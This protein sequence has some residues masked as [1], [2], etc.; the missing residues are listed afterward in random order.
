M[1]KI[2][3]MSLLT[4]T[5][6]FSA[7][8]E[9]LE[10][11]INNGSVKEILKTIDS[12][13]EDNSEKAIKIVLGATKNKDRQIKQK[14]IDYIDVNIE[15]STDILIEEIYSNFNERHKNTLL[16]ILEKTNN[17]VFQDILYMDKNELKTYM[18]DI[19]NNKT[20][21]VIT[22]QKT[23]IKAP[24]KTQKA[25]ETI[26]KNDPIKKSNKYQLTKNLNI[27][28]LNIEMIT[29]RDKA[30]I[31]DSFSKIQNGEDIESN[32][33]KLEKFSMFLEPVLLEGLKDVNKNIRESSLVLLQRSDSLKNI[34][35]NLFDE[36]NFSEEPLAA[37]YHIN[38]A[39]NYE[40]EFLY[41]FKLAS[42]EIQ[43]KILPI[44][45]ELKIN[46]VVSEYENIQDRQRKLMEKRNKEEKAQLAAIK[47]R[48]EAYKRE[49]AKQKQRELA[50]KN[51]SSKKPINKNVE[52]PKPKPKPINKNVELS[53]DEIV[54]TSLDDKNK[55]Y[56][57]IIQ[58]GNLKIEKAIPKMYSILSN[59]KNTKIQKQILFSLTKI[60]NKE[61]IKI[62]K[63]YSESDNKSL[64][65]IA[66]RAL[67]SIE[68][69]N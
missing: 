65:F 37:I 60:G 5:L 68:T 61:S 7:N 66:Q 17:K 46:K 63:E 69:K 16:N 58:V 8:Y 26:K 35:E 50:L 62:L 10:K 47:A 1:K 55:V 64:K 39:V 59:S 52:K 36:L 29:K 49:L 21:L 28:E 25:E 30:K 54:I 20:H 43:E 44:M 6:L 57:A 15:K 56:D 31:I 67:K 9:K 40:N 3:T 27:E 42:S 41:A 38:N 2:L 14:V 18:S 24:S 19:K 32:L 33:K 45:K 11:D 23:E 53:I 51:S 48:E 4:T 12:L 34:I 13:S 22:P